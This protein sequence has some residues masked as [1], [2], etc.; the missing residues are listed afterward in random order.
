MLKKSIFI[1]FG[2]FISL[3]ADTKEDVGVITIEDVSENEIV[4]LTHSPI[5]VSVIDVTKFH[6]RNISLN[7]ILKRVAGV[8]VKQQG[9]L[10]S[11]ATI[12]IQG[13]EGKRIKIYLDGSPLN[14]PD[15]SFG[16]NDIP[17][18]FIERIEVYKGVVPAKFGG[19]SVGGAVN[20]V[21]KEFEDNFDFTYSMGSYGEYRAG[22]VAKKYF[23]KY[24]IEA[25]I[26][27]F[28]NKGANDYIMESPYVDGLK[29]KRDHAGF[30]SFVYAHSGKAKEYW[31]DEISWEL[32]RYESQKEIQGIR[33]PIK[34][35]EN[36][37][38]VNIASIEFEKNQFLLKNLEFKYI[39]TYV[40][41]ELNYIDKATTC[42]NF[43]GSKRPCPGSGIGEIS[44]TPHDSK[45]KQKELR[46]DLNLHYI[47]NNNHAFNF[48]LNS[49]KSEYKPNDELADKSLGFESSAD[50]SD[51]ANTVIS[52]GYESSY[53][54]SKLLNDMGIKNYRYDYSIN[55]RE[56][57]VGVSRQANKHKG[58]ELGVYESVRY[59][60]IKDLFVKASYEHAFR[61]PSNSEIFG[62]GGFIQSAPNLIPEEA[63]NYNLGIL[64]DS[65]DFYGIPWIKLESN[66]FYKNLKNMIKL[67]QGANESGYI[68]LGKVEVKGFE[69]EANVDLTEN[70]YLYSNYT[71]QT[72]LDKQKF[73]TGTNS[74]PSPTYNLDIPNIASQYGNLGIE[75]K[76]LGI[77]RN[78]SLLK[79]FWESNW[80][81]EYFYGFE[82]SKNQSRKID[83][84]FT[85]TAG[86]EYS[87]ND[88]SYIIGFEVRNLS[89]EEIT[90]V[91]NYPLMG[92]TYHL[93][94]RY[95][96]ID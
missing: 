41:F 68:N 58:D 34:E 30:E 38:S 91:F 60:P 93:N 69:L 54:D 52:L 44:G 85:H 11:R 70:W 12:A 37:S 87:F 17:I 16:I 24:R 55:Q 57:V 56:G 23:D 86:F 46:H 64:F 62:D 75:Y 28:Y 66:I 27:G 33:T 79:L 9:G 7:E 76:T 32:A 83:T 88:D 77:F 63:N 82:F 80:V 3:Q 22:F 74:V 29:I 8:R 36:K 61:L 73:I 35:A 40:D 18:Q 59:E 92:R 10:G 42:Y 89:D 72:L 65:Y 47:V 31:F 39:L 43:D 4:K 25:G 96:W 1:I 19:D 14:S 2:I 45:D 21:L 90:D 84:Q 94:F 6:G 50:P 78:D 20:V 71:N 49:K 95:T 51:S 67:Q 48:H 81:D 15:G 5:P 26:G 53:L 13:L